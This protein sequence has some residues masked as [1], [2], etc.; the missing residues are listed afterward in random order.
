[1]KWNI[2]IQMQ[3]T[4]T[5]HALLICISLHFTQGR[6]SFFD[7]VSECVCVN[8]PIQKLRLNSFALFLS[9]LTFVRVL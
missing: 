4:E 5:Q 1:M 6:E 8:T 2:Q 7:S 9:P 3:L